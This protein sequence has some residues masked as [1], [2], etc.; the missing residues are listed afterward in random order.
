[1]CI[2][3]YIKR[4]SPLGHRVVGMLS[5]FRDLGNR[6]QGCSMLPWHCALE[7]A[8]GGCLPGN[9]GTKRVKAIIR[10]F[11]EWVWFPQVPVSCISPGCTGLHPQRTQ[12]QR[13]PGGESITSINYIP[14]LQI[15]KYIFRMTNHIGHNNH[16]PIKQC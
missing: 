3:I 2:Y 5:I 8:A 11:L 10:T 15:C 6:Q 12:G 13:I 9:P 1:M 16:N 4:N 7:M 14:V